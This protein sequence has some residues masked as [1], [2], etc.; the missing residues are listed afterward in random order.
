MKHYYLF[1]VLF[2]S[3]LQIACKSGTQRIEPEGWNIFILPSSIRLDPSTN[4]I[5]NQRFISLNQSDKKNLLNENR[6]YDGEKVQLFSA[7]G[8]Y[9]SFQ[10]KPRVYEITKFVPG[11]SFV[12]VQLLFLFN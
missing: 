5:I 8:E 1:L 12:N 6:I 3:F 4:E 7:R 2:V 10:F 9:V 11:L